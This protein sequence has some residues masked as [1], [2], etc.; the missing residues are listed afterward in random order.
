MRGRIAGPTTYCYMQSMWSVQQPLPVVGPTASSCGRSN[1]LFLWSVQQPLPVVGP[2]ASSCGRSNKPLPVVG[3]T[4]SS[5]GRSNK[6]LPVV[7]PTASSC[8]RSNSLFLWSVQQP[9]LHTVAHHISVIQTSSA[10]QQCEE[11]A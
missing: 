3:P 6:P 1:S 9:L 10:S 8:G 2:T 7:G 5:C 4:A 11:E